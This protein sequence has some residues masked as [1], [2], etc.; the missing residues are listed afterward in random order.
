[1][2]IKKYVLIVGA[3]DGKVVQE[4]KKL[5]ELGFE[6]AQVD[7]LQAAIR[8]LDDLERLSLL[9][10][11]C[12]TNQGNH[13]DFLAHVRGLHPELPVIWVGES[14]GII[15]GFL[16]QPTLHPVSDV[17]SLTDGAAKLLR[18]EFYAN[19][20]TEEVVEAA[21][22]VFREFGVEANRSEPYLKSN[23]TL[24]SDVNAVIGFCGEGLSG[25]LILS[26]SGD[27][28]RAMLSE[29][30]PSE[31]EPGWDDLE[32][33]LGEITNRILGAVKR[34]FEMRALSFKLRTPAFIRGPQARYR[35]QGAAPSI[36]VEFAD[37]RGLVRLEFCLDRLDKGAMAQK[38]DA[39]FVDA[40]Q[41]HFL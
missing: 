26:A 18:E 6:V 9:V 4:A 10:V 3:A 12:A 39:K 25:H 23:L 40:G 14:V 1:M 15:A 11:D 33:L 31:P 32:D 41:V 27:R 8:A 28:A 30:M 37:V 35:K 24:L 20:L 13:H 21:Y 36:A 29:A 16:R 17:P 19:D 38:A 2:F 7:D 22:A 34:V 5:R